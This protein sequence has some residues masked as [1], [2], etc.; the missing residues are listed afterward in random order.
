MNSSKSIR[1]SPFKSAVMAIVII[2]YFVKS[3]AGDSARH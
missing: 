3:I 2:S 1:P